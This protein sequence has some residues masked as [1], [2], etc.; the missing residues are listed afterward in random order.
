MSVILF[1]LI[2]LL[3]ILVH[4]FGH[5]IIAKKFGIRVDEFGVGFPPRAKTLAKIGDTEYTLN[6]IPFGGFVRIFGENPDEESMHGPDSARSFINKPKW[7]Q[8]AVLLGGVFFNMLLAWFLLSVM[9][10]VGTDIALTENN[11]G[12]AQEKRLVISYVYPSSPAGEA[13]LMPEDTILSMSVNEEEVLAELSPEQ[14]TL[15]IT[16]HSEELITIEVERS[17]ETITY[18]VQPQTGI[19]EEDPDRAVIGIG[20]GIVGLVQYSNPFL[21]LIEGARFTADLTV[22]IWDGLMDFFGSILSF[23]ADFSNVAGPVG[24]VPFVGQAAALGFAPLLFLTALISINLAII[25]ILPIPALDGG[26]LL[27]LIIEVVKGSPISP[28]I[29]NATHALFFILLLLLIVVVTYFDIARL[30]TS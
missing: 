27:F 12:F 23:S 3:L 7:V 13:G 24:I 9:F 26:R 6:W 19:I 16:S 1:I 17:E 30:V 29:A 20:M 15:F 22:Y 21:A 28:K 11:E 2:L 8:A 10:M 18:S 5:F 14:A 25:N 4:E